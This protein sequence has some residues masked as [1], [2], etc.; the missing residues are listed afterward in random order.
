MTMLPIAALIL[1]DRSKDRFLGMDLNERAAVVAH[2]AGIEHVYFLG[3]TL[4]DEAMG[5]RLQARGLYVSGTRGWSRPLVGAPPAR[6]L[7]VLPA[8]TVLDP[9][10]L[11]AILAEAAETPD[12][13]S[14]VVDRR[15]EGGHR[16]LSVSGGRVRAVV[17]DGNV[18]STGIAILPIATVE[19][20][21]TAFDMRDAVH[22]LAN[23]GRLRALTAGPRFC[24][25]LPERAD[26][27]AFELD[28]IWHSSGTD[29]GVIA[30]ALHRAWLLV[31]LD[32]PAS[33]VRFA[34][35]R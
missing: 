14:L 2:Q 12:E 23:A 11:R 25:A 21:Q 17:S 1:T 8:R 15:S 34:E 30:T 29:R 19:R 20:L 24:A 13:P 7:A 33:T 5:A 10:A 31:T 26:L 28:Y 35:D 27:A 6:V 3:E 22:R 4:P 9:P 16:F 18:S 32:P